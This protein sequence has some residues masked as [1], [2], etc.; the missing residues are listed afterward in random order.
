MDEGGGRKPKS[1]KEQPE[2]K[3]QVHRAGGGLWLRG[4]PGGLGTQGL[5][6]QLGSCDP[7]AATLLL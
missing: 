4:G 7:A 1:T 5:G 6:T 2:R 3:R